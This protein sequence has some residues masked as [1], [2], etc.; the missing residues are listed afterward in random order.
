M[1]DIYGNTY[2]YDERSVD[3]VVDDY[4]EGDKWHDPEN[5]DLDTMEQLW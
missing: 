4:Q 1:T 3:Q 5:A 2:E